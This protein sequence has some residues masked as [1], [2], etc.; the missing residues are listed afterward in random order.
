INVISYKYRDEK[1]LTAFSILS[2]VATTSCSTVA[3]FPLQTLWNSSMASS[4]AESS[5]T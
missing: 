3:T 2:T 1:Q 5:D 4:V